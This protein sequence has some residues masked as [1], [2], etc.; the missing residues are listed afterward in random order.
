MDAMVTFRERLSPAPWVFIATA[1]VLPA[2]LLVFLP[3]AAEVGIAVAIGL[4]AAI[5]LILIVTTPTVEVTETEL[6]AGRARIPRSL[7]G[8]ATAHRDTE[9]GLERGQRLDTRAWLLIRGWI[10]P[11]VR[12]EIV[13]ENDPT[14]YWLVSTRR[15]EELVRALG[16]EPEVAETPTA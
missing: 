11:V 15:P 16:F 13:D 5:V 7:I 1:L 8:G 9:A 10:S 14:P 4:Y 2:T 6:R 3:I 12:I